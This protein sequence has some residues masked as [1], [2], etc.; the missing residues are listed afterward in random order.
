MLENSEEPIKNGEIRETGNI[1]YTT[2]RNT[3]QRHNTTCVGHHY[4]INE[5]TQIMYK[6][7]KVKMN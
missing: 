3:Q 6:D 4:T 2:Q 5:E 1:V 7:L